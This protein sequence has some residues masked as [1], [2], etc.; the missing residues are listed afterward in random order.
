MF[1]RKADPEPATPERVLL[2][3]D[4]AADAPLRDDLSAVTRV[5]DDLWLASDEGAALERLSRGPGGAFDRHASFPIA[6]FLRLPE[7]GG[8]VDVEGLDESDGWLWLVGSHS[9]RR[10]QP[11]DDGSPGKRMRR[12][13]KVDASPN[14]HLLARIPLVRTADGSWEP[15]DEASD[16][17]APGGVR[18]AG[19]LR[20]GRRR[21]A[22]TRAVRDDEHLA[23]FLG[24]PG[25]DNGFNV[26]GMAVAGDRVF[27][28]LRGPVLRGY[29]MVL[30]LRVQADAD[31]PSRLRLARIGRRGR[32][33]R[34]HFLDLR[35]LG[36]R[37]LCLDGD[38]LL[39]LAGPTMTLDGRATVFRWRGALSADGD[40]IVGRD[41]LQVALELP[42][43]LGD[44]EGVEHPEG[45]AL[46]QT[47]DGRKAVLVV[48]DAPH[49]RRRHG[50]AAVEA[51]LF[52]LE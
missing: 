8:E 28:G 2:A 45:M 12:L 50:D 25:K 37:E 3:F 35:G 7:P 34:K 36:V 31:D 46:A 51:D 19:L 26:E 22:L 30:E 39:I 41:E 38:D 1:S 21:S 33:Y 9:A 5:G 11:D 40:G 32:R 48:Y 29:A 52:P 49:A 16:D 10:R 6:R 18:Q 42:Y 44:D 14:R 23:P 47:E 13:A 15:T 20:V 4:G 17:A 43:G 27:L 24:L